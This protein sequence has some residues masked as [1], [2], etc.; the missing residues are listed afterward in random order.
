MIWSL[1]WSNSS[2]CQRHRNF[3]LYITLDLKSQITKIKLT[4]WIQ[5][6]LFLTLKENQNVFCTYYVVG[7]V[8]GAQKVQWSKCRFGPDYCFCY[9]ILSWS[10]P[11]KQN[12]GW[13]KFM[14]LTRVLLTWQ[15]LHCVSWQVK[16]SLRI[17]AKLGTQRDN[18]L[19]LLT[20]HSRAVEP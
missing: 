12:G 18:S 1:T 17:G 20:G 4:G 6:R 13:R 10:L 7:T 3:W 19:S 9:V 16:A 2:K 14:G 15:V 11:L 8:L 5:L